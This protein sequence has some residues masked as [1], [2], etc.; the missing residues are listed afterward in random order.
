MTIVC[1]TD[2]SDQSSQAMQAAGALA[3]HL[4]EPLKLVHVLANSGNASIPAL[5]MISEPLQN[6]LVA[7]AEQLAVELSI[8]VSPVVLEGP[9]DETLAEFARTEK[10]RLLVVSSLGEHKA[11]RWR[12]G[13]V[14]AGALRR[15]E[16]PVLVVR[17]SESIRDWAAGK[18]PLQVLVGV[19]LGQSA[20][21]ALRW[22]ESLREIGPCD[23][24]VVQVAWPIGE[25]ARFGVKGPMPLEGLHP[26]L[27]ALLERDL[28]AW[29]GALRGAGKT[30]FSVRACWGRVDTEL[31]LLA[32]ESRAD[33]V[34]VGN[35]RKAWSKRFW[36]GS[37]SLGVVRQTQANVGCVPCSPVDGENAEGITRYRS[38]LIP[39]D[40][41]AASKAALAAGYGLLPEGGEVHLLHV[42]TSDGEPTQPNLDARLRALAPPG[43]ESLGIETRVHVVEE[44]EAWSGIWHTASRLGVDAICMATHA[45]SGPARA[46]LGSQAQRV[47]KHAH[48]PVLLVTPDARS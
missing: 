29:V 17:E 24:V 16:V 42:V 22:I 32:Q 46:I 9:A 30:V 44:A 39:T 1:G 14:A 26:E 41:S 21:S 34:V 18:R 25:H 15:S 43:A 35:H 6:M 10:A 12:V 45:R 20:K 19:D 8:R 4:D 2:F 27:K 33:L 37:V 28:R 40:F 3:R 23:V 38:V 13:S 11:E 36:E 5:G 48:Q 47:V 7:Q 31:M